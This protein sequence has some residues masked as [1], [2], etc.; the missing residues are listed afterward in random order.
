MPEGRG[1][2][3]PRVTLDVVYTKRAQRKAETRKAVMAAAR[4]V[5]HDRGYEAATIAA[6]AEEAGV[7]PGTV[8]NAASTKIALL[9]EVMRED[10]EQLGADCENLAASLTSGPRETVGALLEQHLARHNDEIDLIAAVIGHC[11]LGQGEDFSSLY[12]NLDLAWASILDVLKAAQADGKLADG[13]DAA[14]LTAFLQDAYLG[15]LRRSAAE[16][17]DLFAASALMR[18]R[19]DLVLGASLKP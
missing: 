15:V 11:W 2:I 18:Q 9:N 5:F 13:V 8:L 16:E 19:L 7:S 4:T 12:A 1:R 10:F 3:S 6:I 14:P 17:L